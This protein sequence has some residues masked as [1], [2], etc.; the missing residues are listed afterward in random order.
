MK[1]RRERK[2][3][4]SC[5]CTQARDDLRLTNNKSSFYCATYVMLLPL[6]EKLAHKLA[7]VGPMKALQKKNKTEET[8]HKKNMKNGKNMREKG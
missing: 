1:K 5:V 6:C 4:S 8:Q 7:D 2:K 3:K